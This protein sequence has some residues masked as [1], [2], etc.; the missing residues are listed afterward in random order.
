LTAL[1]TRHSLSAVCINDICSLLHILNVPNAPRSWYEV[2]K[3]FNESSFISKTDHKIYWICPSCQN[4]SDNM[5][6]CSNS[7]CDWCFT[8]PALMPNYFYTFDITEQLSLI[9]ATTPDLNIPTRTTNAP[10]LPLSMADIVDGLYYHKILDEESEPFLTLTINT[11]GVQPYNSSEK[12]IWP[13]TLVINEI[14]RK[15]RFCFQNLIIGGIWPGST[16]PKRFEMA[17][18]LE[19]IVVQLKML[20]KGCNF[21]YRSGAS[22]VTRSLKVFLICACMDKPAQSLVQNL[23]EP[24]AQFGCGRCELR[25]KYFFSLTSIS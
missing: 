20:E 24:I 12:S 11:D 1:K 3:A 6:I 22:Y 9:L 17:A 10:H 21:E 5:F 25:G 15:R 18:L 14:K 13:V 16:K 8:P 19:T 23:P 7:N 4:A 2:K